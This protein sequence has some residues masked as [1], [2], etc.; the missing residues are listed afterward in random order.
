M[1]LSRRTSRSIRVREAT[2]AIQRLRLLVD[3][4]GR[5]HL[6]PM[7]CLRRSLVLQWLLGRHG[8]LTNLQIG[9]QKEADELNAHAWL[10]Y[11]GRPIGEPDSIAT[12]YDS[13]ATP[14]A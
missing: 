6:Y 4:A 9:V 11:N 12:R 5:N 1:S 3:V 2:A 8:I 14:E 7:G 13:L 10:E